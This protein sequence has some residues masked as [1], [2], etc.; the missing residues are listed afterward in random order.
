MAK[1]GEQ[2]IYPS[3]EM[4]IDNNRRIIHLTGGFFLPPNNLANPNLLLYILDAIQKPLYG[5]QL[6]P[7]IEMKAAAL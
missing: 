2:I 1:S 5:R 4:I 7:A 3:L 6:F